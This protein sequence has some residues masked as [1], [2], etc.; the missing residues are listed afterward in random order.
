MK[1]LPNGFRE[2]FM[3]VLAYDVLVTL[4][5]MKAND[6][7]AARRDFVRTVFAA[8]EGWIFDY[9]QG[10]QESLGN[11]RDLSPAEEAAFAEATYALSETGKLRKQTRFFPMTA[12]FRF[13]T[14]LVEQEC[15]QSIVDFSSA[16]WQKFGEATVIRNRVTHPK[17][18]D[19]LH[20]SLDEIATVQAAYEWLLTAIFDVESQL[21]TKLVIHLRI[22][23]EVVEALKSGDPAM[24]ELYN[25]ALET[26]DS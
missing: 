14:R 15:G 16:E 17:G 21:K 7:Q 22:L 20:I 24:L 13:A 5:R 25:K 10:V 9:R 12:M 18:I 23:T 19:D 11:I 4:R 6:D 3:G 26:G 1:E 2:T 8:I